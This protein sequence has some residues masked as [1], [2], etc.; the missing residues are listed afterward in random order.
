[1]KEC[2]I[3]D[4][5][6]KV[7][8]MEVEEDCTRLVLPPSV[9]EIDDFA[10]FGN[11]TLREIVLPEGL[12]KI[13]VCAFRECK[14]LK[15]VVFPAS[16]KEIGSSAFMD[17]TSLE[18]VVFTG[19]GPQELETETFSRCKALKT[20]RLGTALRL[21]STGMEL[22]GTF[23][24]CASLEEIVLP[25]GCEI[26]GCA[27]FKDCK[28]LSRVTFPSTLKGV[29]EESLAGTA[30]REIELAE[31]L[32]TFWKAVYGCNE[33]RRI[34]LPSTVTSLSYKEF[35]DLPGLTEVVL[36][37]RFEEDLDLYFQREDLGRIHITFI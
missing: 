25:E 33:L 26:I 27:A 13:G 6:V 10:F 35:G 12:E 24:E 9:K 29:G 3:K 5:T 32:L 28:N 7:D 34:V 16:I 37:K 19:G 31:G 14:A 21:L 36:P 15:A 8:G 23:E 4:G 20:V 1:M 17:C 2:I 11:G 22:G 30:I 18:S